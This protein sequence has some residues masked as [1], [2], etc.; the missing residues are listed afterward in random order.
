MGTPTFRTFQPRNVNLYACCHDIWH[1]AECRSWHCYRG[2]NEHEGE[3]RRN[4]ECLLW[5]PLYVSLIPSRLRLPHRV[6]RGTVTRARA[7][8][9]PEPDDPNFGPLTDPNHFAGASSTFLL[10]G[11][12]KE[13]GHFMYWQ[14]GLTYVLLRVR[15]NKQS[16]DR[17][18]SPR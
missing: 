11:E 1:I 17:S 5:Y 9:E 14:R 10:L 15:W 13:R 16:V 7:T 12:N 2:A 6:E 18:P 4:R 8:D 3:G